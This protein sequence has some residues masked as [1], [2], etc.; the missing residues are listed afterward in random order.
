MSNPLFLLGFGR[1]EVA[2]DAVC[3]GWM[4]STSKNEEWKTCENKEPAV[5]DRH[6][7][8]SLG[9]LDSTSL[10]V[11]ERMEHTRLQQFALTVH[12]TLCSKVHRGQKETTTQ[13]QQVGA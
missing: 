1:F 10:S 9:S 2:V 11:E 12:Q 8:G 13:Q 6:L 5:V 3:L 4:S 7:P